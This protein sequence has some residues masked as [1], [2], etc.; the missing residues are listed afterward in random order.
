VRLRA[1]YNN[2]RSKIVGSIDTPPQ[3]AGF[4]SVLFDRIERRRIEC[5]QPK[6]SLRLGGDWRRNRLGVNVDL[7]RYGRFCSFTA[8][9]ADD[10]EYSPK[11][12]TDLEASYRTAG[13]TLAAG[14]QNLFDVFPDRNF[15]VN[16]FN[17]IQT[18]PSHSPF[19]MN[20]RAIYAR[21]GFTF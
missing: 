19:G 6:D 18:F 5:G 4:E 10:Q 8:S 15:V 7:A 13:Y 20:G 2:T 21:L 1:G 11:W 3:L 17:G 16:S 9:P 12:L 14:V